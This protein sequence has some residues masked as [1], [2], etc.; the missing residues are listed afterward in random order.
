MVQTPWASTATVAEAVCPQTATSAS[1][2]PLAAASMVAVKVNVRVA[3]ASMSA[4]GQLAPAA[5]ATHPSAE[6]AKLMPAGSVTSAVVGTVL[7]AESL[8]TCRV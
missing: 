4:T 7:T 1:R 6:L 2:S 5:S 8:V 3:P